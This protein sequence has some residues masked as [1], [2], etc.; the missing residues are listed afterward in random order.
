MPRRYRPVASNDIER[1]TDIARKMVTQWGMSERLG[2]MLYAEEDGEVFLGTAWPRPS[3]CLTIPPASSMQRSKQVIDR[4][5][6]RAKQILLDNMDVLHTMK[7]ALMKYETI[8]C[9][10]SMI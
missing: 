1:A 10:R 2:P 6:D 8:G 5:Y 9:R 3:T 4:N 7:D